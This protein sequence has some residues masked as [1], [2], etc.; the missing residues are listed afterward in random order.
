MENISIE[1]N[2]CDH[3]T[4]KM[5]CFEIHS[6][7]ENSNYE[8][9]DNMENEEY[10]ESDDDQQSNDQNSSD[11]LLLYCHV[12]SLLETVSGGKKILACILILK[13][14][15]DH[16]TVFKTLKNMDVHT[17]NSFTNEAFT[18]IINMYK[19][20]NAEWNREDLEK[21]FPNGNN[22]EIIN[23]V[24]IDEL[25]NCLFRDGIPADNQLIKNI[26]LFQKERKTQY[27]IVYGSNPSNWNCFLLTHECMYG[28][29]NYYDHGC[30][31]DNDVMVVESLDHLFH[32]TMPSLEV[33]EKY[34]LEA[35][36]R[37]RD[38]TKLDDICAE[39]MVKD[40]FTEKQ[41]SSIVDR[42]R[43]SKKSTPIEVELE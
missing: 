3:D 24:H 35:R 12:P 36:K 42:F 22:L 18:D 30:C 9:E 10:L 15:I 26:N 43:E 2:G 40:D 23:I 27:T 1:S 37:K 34:R 33:I 20:R 5:D 4:K 6:D 14:I 7:E 38:D 19:E 8:E 21:I 29:I 17:K 41:I 16:F 13:K 32:H 31:N 25:Q 28:T 39:A 11:L